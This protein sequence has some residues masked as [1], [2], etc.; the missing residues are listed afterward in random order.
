MMTPLPTESEVMTKN[1]ICYTYMVYVQRFQIEAFGPH[2]AQK[3]S[4][5]NSDWER[6]KFHIILHG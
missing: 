5:S 1:Q 6:I 3:K 4:C 2:A